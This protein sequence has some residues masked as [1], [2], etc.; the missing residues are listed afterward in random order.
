MRKLTR[1]IK[2]LSNV[3]DKHE[4]QALMKK[5]GEMIAELLDDDLQTIDTETSIELNFAVL[6]FKHTIKKKNK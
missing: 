5:S 2:T 3:K 6:K 4:Q 1:N